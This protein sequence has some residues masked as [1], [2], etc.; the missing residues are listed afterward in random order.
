MIIDPWGSELVAD[1]Q[2]I[3]KEFG[4]EEF[5]ADLFP[6]PNTIMRRGVVFA[7]RDLGIISKCI[8][9]KKKFYA[10]SGIMPSG[11]K[12][13]FGNKMVVENLKY[14][15]EHGAKTYILVAD[16]EAAATR[17]VTLEEA[18]KRGFGISHSCIHCIRIGSEENNIL[19]PVRKQGCDAS[20]L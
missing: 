7:G 18:R 6:E 2:R 12:I 9:E 5:K 20:W 1:Y 19:F 11:D 15:Q 14:F 10:L 17:G 4:L 8:K 13:H 16:L 3:I